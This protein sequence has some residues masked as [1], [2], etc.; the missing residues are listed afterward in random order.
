MLQISAL[1]KLGFKKSYLFHKNAVV[2]AKY[3]KHFKMCGVLL[4]KYWDSIECC[5]QEGDENAFIDAELNT[6]HAVRL[7][8]STVKPAT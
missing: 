6:I 8:T 7:R 1:T 4:K 3:S 2:W 5:S